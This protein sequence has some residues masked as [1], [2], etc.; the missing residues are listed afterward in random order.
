MACGLGGNGPDSKST[1]PASCSALTCAADE[2]CDDTCDG[3]H[4]HVVACVKSCRG[5]TCGCGTTCSRTVGQDAMCVAG[6]TACPPQ[7]VIGTS[8]ANTICVGGRRC[9]Q[10]PPIGA[11]PGSVTCVA[12]A[13]QPYPF[14]STT[15]DSSS[16]SP[17]RTVVGYGGDYVHNSLGIPEW[18]CN[19]VTGTSDV[20]PCIYQGVDLCVN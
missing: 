13:S 19:N 11:M 18:T 1:G 6:G 14:C 4:G 17:L 20:F 2:D 15:L 7:D 8:C 10:V 12:P 3:V 5:L 9:L 16:S